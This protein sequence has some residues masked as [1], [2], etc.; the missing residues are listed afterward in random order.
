M[1][2]CNECGKKLGFVAGY[3]HPTRGKKYL[4]CSTC[5][6]NVNE[7]VKQWREFILPYNNYFKNNTSENNG[8][9][10]MKNYLKKLG[11]GFNNLN[12]S[13]TRKEI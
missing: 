1:V 2:E 10:N 4:V 5:F 13:W 8:H 3:R 9:F 11:H 7:S 6:D 12:R